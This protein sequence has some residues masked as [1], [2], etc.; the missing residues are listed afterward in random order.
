MPR[1]FSSAST[2]ET[3]NETTLAGGTSGAI[4]GGTISGKQLKQR[5]AG[6][7]GVKNPQQSQLC[8]LLN[9]YSR[10][11]VP[12]PITTLTRTAFEK[13]EHESALR[14]LTNVHKSW[15]EIV[16]SDLMSEHEFKI[17]NA[18]WEL[19]TTE[20]DYIHCLKTVTDVSESDLKT[21]RSKDGNWGIHFIYFMNF[22]CFWLVWKE[23]R[24]R[25][26]CRT[27]INISYL[28]IF[29]IFARRISNFGRIICIRW[30]SIV[31]ER[32]S[33]F[34]SVTFKAVLCNLPPYLHHTNDIVPNKVAVSIIAKS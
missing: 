6:L 18:I 16:N 26:Y 3:S 10:D 34:A 27:S 2:D 11:G 29:V 14:Y 22:S 31:Y 9:T 32:R 30:W 28:P 1:L 25:I 7:F 17:Q 19:V 21:T 15:R 20:V 23:F 8:E 5:W 33:R 24:D 13:N 12:K 4:S